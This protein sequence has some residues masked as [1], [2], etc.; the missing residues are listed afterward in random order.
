MD[1]ESF[2]SGGLWGFE[3][4]LGEVAG[5]GFVDGGVVWGC[6]TGCPCGWKPVPVK[7]V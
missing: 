1:W 2:R 5:G 4:V 3:L 7:K 6:G